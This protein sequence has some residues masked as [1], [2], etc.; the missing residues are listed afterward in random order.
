MLVQECTK[1]GNHAKHAF[2][3]D[4]SLENHGGGGNSIRRG[5]IFFL[6]AHKIICNGFL[7]HIVRVKDL[8]SDIPLSVLI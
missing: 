2:K 8:E 6:K 7:Y 3:E 4:I 5:H 1:Y